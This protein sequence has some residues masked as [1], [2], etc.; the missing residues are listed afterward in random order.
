MMTSIIAIL[1]FATAAHAADPKQVEDLLQEGIRLRREGSDGRALPLF[2]KAHEL[3]HTPRTAAQLGLVEYALG[4]SLDAATH[5]SQGLAASNDVWIRSHRAVLEDALA[6]VRGTIGELAVTGSPDGAEVI[7]NGKSVGRLPLAAPV[8]SGQ[9]P[10][11]LELRAP[12]YLNASSSV[13]V[14]GGKLATVHLE[15]A[16][17]LNLNASAPTTSLP[18]VQ[19]DSA[20][21]ATAAPQAGSATRSVVGWSLIGAGAIA[22]ATGAILLLG[23]NDCVAMAGFECARKPPSHVP[24]WVLLGGGAAVGIAGTI[25]LV[26]RP[27]DRT[28]IGLGPTFV[29]MRAR[30]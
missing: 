4:Y 28:E 12:G 14:V 3:A 30:L 20:K 7:L 19:I 1:A 17:E 21:G 29:F 22:S 27:T 10:A 24:A 13:S 25:V 6:Q 11:T 15:L 18:V 5:L 26:T 9:G 16:R 2:Q 23:A 8:A